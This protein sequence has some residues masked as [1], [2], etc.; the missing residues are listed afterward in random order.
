[1]LRM[2]RR[3]GCTRTV[4]LIGRVAIKVPSCRYGTRFFVNGLMNNLEE[5][6]RWY[7][8]THRNH[9]RM[10]PVRLCGPLGL[11]LVMDRAST[12]LVNQQ[13][14]ERLMRR[15]GICMDANGSNC[16]VINKR[17]VIVDYGEASFSFW[18]FDHT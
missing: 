13:L 8:W 5:S 12:E 3:F 14:A 1:M 17:V 7:N 10:C 18:T 4:F 15:L 9:D 11:F 16:G 2:H 6:Y